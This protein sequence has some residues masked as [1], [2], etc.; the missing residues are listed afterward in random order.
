MIENQ[1]Q[2]ARV[3]VQAHPLSLY[4]PSRT[5]LQCTVQLRGQMHSPYFISIPIC[6][7]WCWSARY[8]SVV[9]RW[10]LF[11]D[12][13]LVKDGRYLET[14]EA[15]NWCLS[16]LPT[17]PTLSKLVSE[18]TIFLLCSFYVSVHRRLSK[19]PGSFEWKWCLFWLEIRIKGSKYLQRS[20]YSI[21]NTK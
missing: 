7:L 15:K 12:K 2:L 4:L 13:M 18:I 1:P 3:G 10:Y 16:V 19:K 14:W 20:W 8:L 9:R 17:S 6:N 21:S 5:K 11:R